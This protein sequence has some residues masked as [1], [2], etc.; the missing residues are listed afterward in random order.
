MRHMII[1]WYVDGMV[2]NHVRRKNHTFFQ[3][4]RKKVIIN[5]LLRIYKT[6]IFL[7]Q[8]TN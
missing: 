4:R 1:W 6:K 7:I 8:K 2:K 3:K 5:Y